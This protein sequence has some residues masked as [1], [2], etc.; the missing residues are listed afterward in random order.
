M[1]QVFYLPSSGQKTQKPILSIKPIREKPQVRLKPNRKA[2]H[3]GDS[4]YLIIDSI[5]IAGNKKTKPKVILRELRLN[6]GDTIYADDIT[7]AFEEKRQQLI[8]TSLF[9]TVH[10]YAFNTTKHHTDIKVEV[11]ER[12]YFLVIPTLSLAD[13]N[14][15]VWWVDEHHKLD[16]L[17]YGIKLYQNNMTGKNDRLSLTLQHGYTRK[18]VLDYQLPYF[19]KNLKQG[20]GVYVSYSHNRE[21]NFRSDSNKQEYLKQDYFLK[22]ELSFGINY[23]YKK[24]IRLKHKI[25]LSYHAEKVKDT[26]LKLNPD[27]FPD[28]D[29]S[30]QYL[31]LSYNFNYTGADI[32]A[33][34]LRGFNISAGI[35][36]KG[37]GLMS[38]VDETSISLDAS[39]YWTLLPKTFAETE[40]L[41]KVHF[42]VN[43]PYFLLQ[44]MGYYGH[45]LRGME[46]YVLESDRFG[47][48]RNT[49]KQQILAVRVNSRWLP[50]QFASIPFHIYLKAY[51][52]LGYSY[53]SRPGTSTLDNKLL[54][55][56]GIGADIVTFYDAVLRVDYSFNQ[57]HQKGLFLHF[58][59]TF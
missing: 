47:I 45:Y 52:D 3:R 11:L 42:P 48:I 59:S 6:T 4:D 9:L 31:E 34:P 5:Y 21:V 36:R 51:G 17:N 18:Y 29:P 39:K 22:Q 53:N 20:L 32:W 56:Y 13:R 49:L 33:Y 16:R 57:L 7:A 41:G 2:N 40:F 25:S 43:Q 28:N 15:N 30:Q 26:V 50:R 10:I 12:Q 8:N 54:Y 24:A 23:T 58:K 35:V 44:E 37:F 1:L 46:Y 27:F 55:T 38:K 19:D 14:F